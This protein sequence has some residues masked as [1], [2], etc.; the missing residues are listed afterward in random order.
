ME[1]STTRQQFSFLDALYALLTIPFRLSYTINRYQHQQQQQ[2]TPLTTNDFIKDH[3]S[4]EFDANFYFILDEKRVPA[5]V[6]WGATYYSVL[7]CLW[8]TAS[9]LFD[10]GNYFFTNAE[11]D[12]NGLFAIPETPTFPSEFMLQTRRTG[13]LALLLSSVPASIPIRL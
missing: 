13:K 9:L 2:K 6:S 8:I 4:D 7:F 3:D 10:V 5:I 11:A 1:A 12:L